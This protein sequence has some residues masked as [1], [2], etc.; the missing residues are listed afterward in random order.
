MFGFL[1]SVDDLER[2]FREWTLSD[3]IRVFG[4][5]GRID[6]SKEIQDSGLV[7]LIEL[8]AAGIAMHF[9]S[10]NFDMALVGRRTDA[11]LDRH[12]AKGAK[13]LNSLLQKKEWAMTTSPEE[14]MNGGLIVVDPK[15]GNRV[16]GP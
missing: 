7:W 5:A 16:R 14:R 4:E 10:A 3:R 6:Q 8:S 15:T 12:F 13:I 1:K 11:H 9:Q 2:E